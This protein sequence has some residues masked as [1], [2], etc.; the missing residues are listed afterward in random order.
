MR[1]FFGRTAYT[2]AYNPVNYK[3]R[4]GL[5]ARPATSPFVF[6]GITIGLIA[7]TIAYTR[8]QRQ[9]GAEAATAANAKS[10]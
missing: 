2:I 10:I 3:K 1:R 8:R 6:N 4:K 9:R 7:W 5:D